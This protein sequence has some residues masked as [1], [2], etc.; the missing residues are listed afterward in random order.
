MHW[1]DI[2]HAPAAHAAIRGLTIAPNPIAHRD[3]LVA[4]WIEEGATL[5][6]MA[7]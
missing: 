1:I 3:Q 2:C 5:P 7:C 4:V 6:P